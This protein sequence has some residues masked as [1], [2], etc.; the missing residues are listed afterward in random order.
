MLVEN[1]THDLAGFMYFRMLQPVGYLAALAFCLH[2]PG[3]H[4][5]VDVFGEVGF[6]VSSVATSSDADLPFPLRSSR[7]SSR[8]GCASALQISHCISSTLRHSLRS[9]MVSF[10]VY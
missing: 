7:I 5:K 10:M 3:M 9:V 1:G 6:E 4:E 2:D 8:A